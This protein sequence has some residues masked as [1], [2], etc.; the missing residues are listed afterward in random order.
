MRYSLHQRRAG[1]VLVQGQPGRCT[2]TLTVNVT[3]TRKSIKRVYRNSDGVPLT[4]E[5]MRETLRVYAPGCVLS[6]AD[7]ASI[8]AMM[9]GDWDTLTRNG[10]NGER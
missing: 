7:F 5:V 6:H 4:V 10:V 3:K 2:M 8:L 1:C 9:Q